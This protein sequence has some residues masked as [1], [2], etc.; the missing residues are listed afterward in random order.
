[1]V[2]IIEP[3]RGRILDPACGSGGMFVHSGDFV[4]SHQLLQ[5]RSFPSTASRRSAKHCAWRR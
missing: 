5:K 4:R 1:M 2:E 3:Y